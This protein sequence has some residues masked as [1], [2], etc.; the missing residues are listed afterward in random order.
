MVSKTQKEKKPQ[1]C[2]HKLKLVF[3]RKTLLLLNENEDTPFQ[4]KGV[5]MGKEYDFVP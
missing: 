2:I 5:L 3:T 1:T 4:P